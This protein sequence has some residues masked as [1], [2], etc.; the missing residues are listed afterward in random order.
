MIVV[1]VGKQLTSGFTTASRSPA[2]ASVSI[3]GEV[4][5]LEMR[6]VGV[7]TNCAI[8]IRQEEAVPRL[9]L[10]LLFACSR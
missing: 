7:T 9:R 8:R 6:T 5:G 4:V 2:I 3:A 10:S 1:M